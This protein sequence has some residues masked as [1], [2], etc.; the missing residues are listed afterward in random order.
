ME[1]NKQ[2]KTSDAQNVADM[3]DAVGDKIPALLRNITSSLYSRE[4]GASMGQAVGA[5]YKE[6]VDAGIPV[7][8]ALEMA[9]DYSFSLRHVVNQ[10][11]GGGNTSDGHGPK[12]F[13]FT[14]SSN[15][16][17]KST[18]PHEEP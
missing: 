13:S 17:E 3:L 1:D 11:S 10:G 12:G 9:K 7:Q 5:Y 15:D 18:D 4:T 8:A 2:K 14:Y 16:E 6:L